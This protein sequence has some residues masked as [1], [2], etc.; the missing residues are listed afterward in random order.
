ML[1]PSRRA[2][3][4]GASPI[5]SLIPFAD[6]A[7]QEGKNIFHLNIGQPDIETP[8]SALNAIK[9][10]DTSIVNYG[11]SLFALLATCDSGD[12][13][14]IPEPFYANYLGFSHMANINIVPIT[15]VLETEFALPS[16]SDFEKKI[17]PKTK[18]IFLCNP[19]NPTGQLYTGQQSKNKPLLES[20]SK[21]AQLRLCPPY[22]GQR[23]ALA[24][25]ENADQYIDKARSEYRQRR[26][27]LFDSLNTIP[28]LTFYKPKAAFY[29]IVALPVK[30]AHAYCQWLLTDFDHQGDT[31]MLTP[32][33]GFYSNRQ[34]GKNQVRIAYILESKKLQKAIN[35]LRIS[36]TEYQ[37]RSDI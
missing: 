13:V 37:D 35:C 22:F 1:N 32:G 30:N 12:E 21:Y 33:N 9:N 34:M 26:E 25:Y 8:Q 2:Q 11:P 16:P 24:C 14:I 17:T 6:R 20:I 19:G 10:L 3:E 18:A 29:N 31:I 23:L 28:G 27:V 5:R 36:L 7:K 4:I 15:T